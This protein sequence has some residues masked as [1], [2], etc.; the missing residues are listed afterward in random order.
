MSKRLE[1]AKEIGLKAGK[2]AMEFYNKQDL[3]VEEK[4]GYFEDFVTEA[5][6]A[7]EK[8]IFK[9]LRKAFPEDDFTGEESSY[10]QSDKEYVWII[11][12]I[13]GTRDF[14]KHT[15]NF[16]IHIGL[17]QNGTG[18]LG[19]V[20]LPAKNKFFY[21]EK[22]KGAFLND[23][24]INVSTIKKVNDARACRSDR[25]KQDTE[26]KRLSELIPTKTNEYVQSSGN[27]IT[28]IAE[29][30]YELTVFKQRT[31]AEWDVCA[32]GVI[33]EEAGGTITTTDEKNLRY[34]KKELD[35]P[36]PII[37]SNNHIHKEVLE[38]FS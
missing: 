4:G 14:I 32:P 25:V 19:V 15:G 28:L 11:D 27:K 9:E 23:K 10:S 7:V 31:V 3:V 22:N 34:N 1:I 13:D 26:L 5:D 21:A 20:Y 6:K 37:V 36:L 2:L 38:F 18:V 30:K 8:F 33:L 35:Y 24:K 16:A 29:G 12:P 17:A